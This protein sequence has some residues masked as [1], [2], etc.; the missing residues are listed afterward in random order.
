MKKAIIYLFFLI[1]CNLIFSIDYSIDH[2]TIEKYIDKLKTSRLEYLKYMKISIFNSFI[3]EKIETGNSY[4]EVYK[5]YKKIYRLN[6]ESIISDH[7]FICQISNI[8]KRYKD[9]EI[10]ILTSF[11][12]KE[13]K[14]NKLDTFKKQ[15]ED[16]LERNRGN[17]KKSVFK[18]KY[19]KK[20]YIIN[21]LLIILRKHIEI[22]KNFVNL[23]NIQYSLLRNRN[24]E[25]LKSRINVIKKTQK[26]LDASLNKNKKDLDKIWDEL[27]EI[28]RP[29][30]K[31]KIL[32]LTNEQQNLFYRAF[33]RGSFLCYD[34]V[35]FKKVYLIY[36]KNDY[37]YNDTRLL[38]VE[39]ESSDL[40]I[41]E[42]KETRFV[43]SN[44]INKSILQTLK[45][46]SLEIPA[47]K[48]DRE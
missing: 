22:K 31:H 4:N 34:R 37:Y 15:C 33:S 24:T 9:K 25:F 23:L 28:K 14:D 19:G 17:I 43:L 16:F 2:H 7:I 20:R 6:L 18:M 5:K 45:K 40:P 42:Y 12:K 35:V 10:K 21:Q 38:V 3:L 1:S 32:K 29:K 13:K 48:I 44:A 30:K 27:S 47:Y 41:L 8:S 39:K 36:K 46:Y 26:N 11:C